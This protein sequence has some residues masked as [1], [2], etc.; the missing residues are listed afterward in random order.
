MMLTQE[1]LKELFQY[2][3]YTGVFTRIKSTSS[4]AIKGDI[5][6][7][8]NSHGYLR[9]CVDGVVYLSHRLAWLYVY[10][11]FPE[12]IMDHI[13]GDRKDNR[14]ANLRVVSLRQNALNRKIQSTNTSGIKGVSWCRNSKKWKA[15]IM[16]EGKHINVG[17][18]SDK[19]EAAEAIKKA[20]AEIHGEFANDGGNAQ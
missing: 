18:F 15:S 1:R 5:A 2:N 19:Q 16:Y 11:E 17:S 4:R 20:R 13:N 9:F 10:G 14:I 6:G 3:S 12:G 7:T 8:T